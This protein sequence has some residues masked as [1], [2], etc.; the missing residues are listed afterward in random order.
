M[1]VERARAAR[2]LSDDAHAAATAAGSGLEH[3]GITDGAGTLQSFALG[4][5]DLIGAGEDGDLGL[6]HGLARG[7]FFAHEACDLGRRA[8]EFDIGGAANFGEVG[9]LAEQAV[10]GMDCV[11]IGDLGGGDDG[12]DVEV[13]LGGARR[14]NADGLVGKADVEAV[15]VSLTVD[16]D[17]ADAHLAAGGDDAQGDLTTVCDH[18]LTK[19]VNSACFHPCTMRL[20]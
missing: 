9:V 19:H 16:G 8:D 2:R 1:P 13:A 3:D 17:G 15:A 6:L 18:N 11:D 7:A 12:R 5:D 20:D 14:A 4:G 10:A